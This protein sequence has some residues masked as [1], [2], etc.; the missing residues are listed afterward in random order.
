MAVTA[1]SHRAPASPLLGVAKRQDVKWLAC[2]GAG[3]LRVQSQA[4]AQAL[5]AHGGHR[6]GVRPDRKGV[7]TIDTPHLLQLVTAYGYIG[8]AALVLI[9]AAGVPLP[10][11]V[12]LFAVGALSAT[13]HGPDVFVLM[14]IGTVAA[15]CGDSLDYALGRMGSSL[16]RNRVLQLLQRLHGSSSSGTLERLW[17]HQHAAVFL[18]RC[19]IT[20]LSMPV[21]MLAGASRMPIA[22][23]LAL[24]VAGKGLF[25][26]V[27]LMLG[28]WFGVALLVHG[29]LTTI[30]WMAGA[31]GLAALALAE[32]RR[33]RLRRAASLAVP[34]MNASGRPVLPRVATLLDEPSE[35]ARHS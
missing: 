33:W 30:F 23:F 35:S 20:A 9:A 11:S 15:A 19:L 4:C 21:S 13:A 32:V 7:R 25:V 6:P 17:R 16:V 12:L 27:C 22:R 18:T 31:L 3:H 14:V 8:Y 28:R 5:R 34:K 29:H 10:L 2:G 1:R 24:D 26:V